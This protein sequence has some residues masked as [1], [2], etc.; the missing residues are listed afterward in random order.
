M[1][2]PS[3]KTRSRRGIG[4]VE[5]LDPV[6]GWQVK[7]NVSQDGR[8]L[9]SS[10]LALSPITIG[11]SPENDIV[12]SHD[13]VS[14][15]HAVLTVSKSR[16][17][18]K[19]RSTNGSFVD[20]EPITERIL[21]SEDVVSVPPFELRFELQMAPRRHKTVLNEP[22]SLIE[23]DPDL[24]PSTSYLEVV[25][26]PSPH[27]GRVFAL[28]LGLYQIGR[29]ESAGI[30]LDVQTVSRLH[31]RLSRNSKGEWILED[32]SSGNGTFVNEEPIKKTVLRSGDQISLGED[33]LL[34]FV[35]PDAVG[36]EPDVRL[37]REDPARDDVD[38]AGA[39][40]LQIKQRCVD[41][42]GKILVLELGG[43]IDSHN[44]AEFRE[45]L[46]RAFDDGHRYLILDL[47]GLF[48]MD[49]AGLGVLVHCATS[50]DQLEGELRLAGVNERLRE[51]FSL[52][53]LDVFFKGRMET[54]SDSAIRS[55]RPHVRWNSRRS[56]EG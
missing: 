24:T 13:Y 23:S 21:A 55:I 14:W 28:E 11:A 10:S 20:G 46:N 2:F 47:S 4:S 15:E 5:G 36:L 29:T 34:T 6:T 19:D 33:L 43:R 53:R 26:A 1:A 17:V 31:A 22:P 37:A 56:S 44:Y 52:S 50:L 7:I 27:L 54:D 49:H 41:G 12:L 25:E 32:L 48:F 8:T 9:F 35:S 40:G 18:Y 38:T 30:R 3:Q 16:L 39:S 45:R 51:A 42:E